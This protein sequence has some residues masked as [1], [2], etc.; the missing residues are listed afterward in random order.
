ML[1]N[2]MNAQITALV[3]DH[4]EV[5]LHGTAAQVEEVL[6]IRWDVAEEADNKTDVRKDSSVSASDLLKRP[7]L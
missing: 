2:I 6:D 4:E 7:V 1:G 3:L 5:L